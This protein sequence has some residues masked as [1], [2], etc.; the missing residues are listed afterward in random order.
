ML[1]DPESIETPAQMMELRERLEE[2]LRQRHGYA[3]IE[4]DDLSAS[5]YISSEKPFFIAFFPINMW[6]FWQ[7]MQ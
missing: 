5:V 1:S 4:I 3:R 6:L 7:V 2:V